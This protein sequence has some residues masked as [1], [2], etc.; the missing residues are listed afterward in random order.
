MRTSRAEREGDLA[1]DAY[2]DWRDTCLIV[3]ATYRCWQSAYAGERRLAYQAYSY[4]L[5]DEEAS[6][7]VYERLA[8]LP[9]ALADP[10][11]L[12]ELGAIP[13]AQSV[14]TAT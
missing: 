2:L 6:A 5:D 9:D 12:A 3:R 4:A 7:A 10:D 14:G 13:A 8:A 11:L 1:V